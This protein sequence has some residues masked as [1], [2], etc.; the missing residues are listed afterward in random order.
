M[1]IIL[2]HK[3]K[4]AMQT[5]R[6]TCIR[7]SEKGVTAFLQEV[8]VWVLW[9][10]GTSHKNPFHMRRIVGDGF[11]WGVPVVYIISLL[12]R[13]LTF[14]D[15]EIT[16]GPED[17]VQHLNST[18]KLINLTLSDLLIDIHAVHYNHVCSMLP[19]GTHTTIGGDEWML[20]PCICR[21]MLWQVIVIGNA[22]HEHARSTATYVTF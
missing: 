6:A 12:C 21:G 11:V 4:W 8:D 15:D 9:H 1:T 16:V 20:E 7:K 18:W 14:H 2:L 13:D 19:V 3:H 22:Q 5:P 17:T 10:E